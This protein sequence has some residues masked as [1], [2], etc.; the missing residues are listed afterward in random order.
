[1][2]P[3]SQ[4]A[5]VLCSYQACAKGIQAKNLFLYIVSTD[6]ARGQNGGDKSTLAKLLTW[7]L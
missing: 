6:G 4:S 3:N 7:L 2:F 5:Q 1:M